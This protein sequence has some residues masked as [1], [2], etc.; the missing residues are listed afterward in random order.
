MILKL[1]L[2][3]AVVA[4][5]YFFF[6]KKKSLMKNSKKDKA[7]LESNDMVEC[8]TCGVYAE[9]DDSILS[10]ASYYCSQECLDKRK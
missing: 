9:V 8:S 4:I 1:L 2:V 3:I 7:K 10:G 5:V 6:I